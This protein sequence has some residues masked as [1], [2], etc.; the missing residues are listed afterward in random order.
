MC[1]L[2]AGNLF[3]SL[4]GSEEQINFSQ[5]CPKMFKITSDIFIHAFLLFLGLFL[6]F[7]RWVP[8]NKWCIKARLQY[9][10]GGYKAREATSRA[11]CFVF[12]TLAVFLAYL[13]DCPF[14]FF[15]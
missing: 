14:R 15:V 9:L 7:F 2:L 4:A 5:Q 3:I 13:F 6:K 12:N 11:T 10:Q 1:T 8:L